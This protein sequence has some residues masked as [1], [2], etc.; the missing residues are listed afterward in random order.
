MAK[1]KGE[2]RAASQ[3]TNETHTQ[4]H[5]P[6]HL[7]VKEWQL[8]AHLDL[9]LVAGDVR[10]RRSSGSSFPLAE[11]TWL[12]QLGHRMHE[13]RDLLVVGSALLIVGAL[14][15]H[16]TGGIGSSVRNQP[17]A[18][19]Y[20][21]FFFGGTLICQRP[22]LSSPWDPT[23]FFGVVAKPPELAAGPDFLDLMAFCATTLVCI[24]TRRRT[25]MPEIVDSERIMRKPPYR[26]TSRQA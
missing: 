12:T 24:P 21:F 15:P 22:R 20:S 6:R 8:M 3:K 4:D 25:A 1:A 13:L 23:R 17:S 16:A 2:I 19:N 9:S 10:S 11:F 7:F 18:R 5:T 26:N 14:W